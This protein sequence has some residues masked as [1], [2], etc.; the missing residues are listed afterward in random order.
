MSELTRA[1]GIIIE[2]CLGARPGEDA[3]VI[4]DEGTR[5]I[6]EALRQAAAERGSDAV[7]AIMDESPQHPERRRVGRLLLAAGTADSSRFRRLRH[8]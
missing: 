4:A 3:L 5:T 6:G 7:L 1:V 8:H 2:H